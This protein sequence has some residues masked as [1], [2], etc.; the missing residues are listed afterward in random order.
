ME[1]KTIALGIIVLLA[2]LKLDGTIDTS[3]LFVTIIYWLPIILYATLWGI[4]YLLDIAV[5]GW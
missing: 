3:W 5:N 2:A 1:L 4:K